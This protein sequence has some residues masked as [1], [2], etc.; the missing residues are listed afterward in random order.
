MRVDGDE[1][2]PSPR[3]TCEREERHGSRKNEEEKYENNN[4]EMGCG[5]C[6]VTTTWGQ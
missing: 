1:E 3:A 6:P 2:D 4:D 5:V